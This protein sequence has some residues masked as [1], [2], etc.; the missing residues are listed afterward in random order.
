MQT[1][2]FGLWSATKI[3]QVTDLLR[4][5]D[6]KFEVTENPTTQEMLR[7][8]CAWD[9]TAANP[10]V[11]FDLWISHVDIPKVGTKIV[12]AFPERKFGAA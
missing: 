7:E 6:V 2:Y 1:T 8:W 5:L 3:K 12:E 10:T 11:G 9:P 4:D